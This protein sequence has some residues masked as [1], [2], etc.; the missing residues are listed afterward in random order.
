MFGSNYYDSS[1][2]TS[3][4]KPKVSSASL[5]KKVKKNTPVIRPE[6]SNFKK[7]PK[8]ISEPE[9]SV[10]KSIEKN[11]HSWIKNILNSDIYK[12]AS[13]IFKVFSGNTISILRQ[14]VF[15]AIS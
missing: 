6:N 15:N 7:A 12:L 8:V 3:V 10:P 11:R 2:S 14:V 1:V 5:N 9:F 4:S 13:F